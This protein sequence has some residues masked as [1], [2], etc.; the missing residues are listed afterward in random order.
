MNFG[1]TKARLDKL[2]SNT[3]TVP[4]NFTCLVLIIG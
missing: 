3:Y 4:F 1:M 2:D